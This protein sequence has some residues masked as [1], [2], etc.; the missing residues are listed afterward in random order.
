MD[1]TLLKRFVALKDEKKQLD[2]KLKT[3]AQTLKELDTAIVPQLIADG[4]ESMNVDG[5]TVYIA[6]DIF[7]GPIDGEKGNVIDALKA[8][9][10]TSGFVAENFSAQTLT[11]YVR[12]V[13]ADVEAACKQDGRLF[14]VEAVR[15][16]LPPRIAAVIKIAFVHNLRSR[17]A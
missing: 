12:E 17:K 8:V 2:A 4:V 9:D 5:Q 15:A 14:D 7:A 11:S 10:E 3:I 13:A 6:N 1:M 16:G